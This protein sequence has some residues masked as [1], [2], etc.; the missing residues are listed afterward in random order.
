[1]TP[2]TVKEALTWRTD[3]ALWNAA[4]VKEEEYRAPKPGRV[5]RGGDVA[6]ANCGIAYGERGDHAGALRF[7]R[8]AA[9]IRESPETLTHISNATFQMGQM[10]ESYLAAERAYRLAP[11]D[12]LVCESWG[13]SLYIHGESHRA[14]PILQRALR[15][16]PDFMPVRGWIG[17]CLMDLGDLR[18]AE[19]QLRACI[20][21]SPN[22]RWVMLQYALVLLQI[23]ELDGAREILDRLHRLD[24]AHGPGFALRTGAR[25]LQGQP[26]SD[27]E[28]HA[29]L[30]ALDNM[31]LRGNSIGVV[32]F[33]R[34]VWP[35][36]DLALRLKLAGA[37]IRMRRLDE[38]EGRLVEMRRIWPD[39][40]DV[41]ANLGLVRLDMRRFREA[42][43][44]L[45]EALA[46]DPD[47]FVLCFALARA[48]RGLGQLEE[49]NARGRQA[50]RL[51]Q[52][53]GQQ[54]AVR[55]FL[56]TLGSR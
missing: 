47:S 15:L 19:E 52:D 44:L 49:A 34:A 36:E 24:P 9:G 14:L 3:Y 26:V 16:K 33:L 50:F 30:V 51:A 2:L 56:S 1:V 22:D 29:M 4:V 28:R 42:R 7:F 23:G 45:A 11:D 25:L 6:L 10:E 43:S 17:A 31:E 21:M 55:E 8:E 35:V 41:L 12:L 54:A 32:Q 18:A 5:H 40:L 46:Q 37:L 48:H 38:A 13:R 20:R 39:E 53:A 27:E